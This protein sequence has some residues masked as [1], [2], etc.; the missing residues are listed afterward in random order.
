MGSWIKDHGPSNNIVLSSRV[1][2]AR[3]LCN[4]PFPAMLTKEG[5]SEVIHKIYDEETKNGVFKGYKFKANRFLSLC[6]SF[7]IGPKGV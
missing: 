7:D 1:R 6:N 3:N 4:I 5:S 2:L